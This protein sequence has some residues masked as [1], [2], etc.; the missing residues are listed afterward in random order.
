MGIDL[1]EPNTPGLAAAELEL[2]GWVLVRLNLLIGSDDDRVAQGVREAR[3]AARALRRSQS[4]LR[5]GRPDAG[6][7]VSLRERAA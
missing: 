4:D 7:V 3:R 6:G 1:V 5:L 2:V